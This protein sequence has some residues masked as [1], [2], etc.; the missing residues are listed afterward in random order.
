MKFT[1]IAMFFVSTMAF[2]GEKANYKELNQG[3]IPTGI[4]TMDLNEWGQSGFCEC[5]PGES[6][7]KRSGLCMKSENIPESIMVQGAIKLNSD[8]TNQISLNT[9][10]GETFLLILKSSDRILMESLTGKPFEVQGELIGYP[11]NSNYN[12]AIIVKE[13]NILE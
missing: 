1:A 11:V 7:D 12:P 2:S 13:L 3:R 8:L 5:F 10:S 6:Y 9:W 4:C